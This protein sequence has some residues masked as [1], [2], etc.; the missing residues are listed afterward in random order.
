ML[1]ALLQGVMRNQHSLDQA[2]QWVALQLQQRQRQA[3]QQR[4]RGRLAEFVP[5]RK[6]QAAATT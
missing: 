4:Q 1:K 3:C 5:A 2:D 6:R